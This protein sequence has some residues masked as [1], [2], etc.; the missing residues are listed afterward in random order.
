MAFLPDAHW[1]A[2]VPTSPLRHFR[3]ISLNDYPHTVITNCPIK[4]EERVLHYLTGISYLDKRLWGMMIRP[5]RVQ[6]ALSNSQQHVANR[7]LLALRKNE[8]NDNNIDD[9]SGGFG[10]YNNNNNNSDNYSNNNK[11][12]SK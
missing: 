6:A 8:H 7:I 10:E 3:L 1:N 9:D 5:I 12:V 4:I 2:L 11:I